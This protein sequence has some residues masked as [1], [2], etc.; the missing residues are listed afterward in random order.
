MKRS[1]INAIL[2]GAKAFLESMQFRLPTWAAWS[3]DD[4]RAHRL[5]CREVFENRLG[6]DITDFGGGD[7]VRR[8]LVL[9]TLRNGHPER[10]KKPYAEKVMVVGEAQETPMH[11]HRSKMEDI[12]NRGGGELVIELLA[13]TPDGGAVR[14]PIEVQIDGCRR[15]VGPGERVVL[16]PGESICLYQD[17]YHRF[18][19]QPGRGPVLAGEVSSVNDDIGDNRFLE[20]VG[21]FP[22]IE[23]DESPLHLLV[24]DYEQWM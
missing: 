15:N 23:E 3:P 18:Y 6:W 16:Q 10:D 22:V 8:G 7:F 12:I 14:K 1:E 20:L 5:K 13:S 4:W 2:G 11:C 24:S 19:A 17:L 21:R 9:F